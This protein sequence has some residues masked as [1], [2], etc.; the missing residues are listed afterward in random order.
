MPTQGG[1]GCA[2]VPLAFHS[3][4]VLHE[5]VSRSSR[6]CLPCP[7]SSAVAPRKNGTR[8][9]YTSRSSGSGSSMEI[10][11]TSTPILATTSNFVLA[12]PPAISSAHTSCADALP[13]DHV[14]LHWCAALLTTLLLRG[15]SD[16]V[17]STQAGS[18][19]PKP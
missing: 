14:H 16:F 17:G 4:S 18:L 1:D 15:D 12:Y 11:I 5:G 7:E 10:I 8:N 6:S 13:V 3:A 9:C 2:K 19:N